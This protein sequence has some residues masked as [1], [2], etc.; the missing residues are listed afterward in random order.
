MLGGIW[1][2]MLSALPAYKEAKQKELAQQAEQAYREALIQQMRDQ[3]AMRLKEFTQRQQEYTDAA[4]QREANLGLTKEQAA[5]AAFNNTFGGKVY[6]AIVPAVAP[7]ITHV[8]GG[9]FDRWAGATPDATLRAQIDREQITSHER[10]TDKQIAAQ[11]AIAAAKAPKSHEQTYHEKLIRD[12]QAQ[13]QDRGI[14]GSLADAFGFSSLVPQQKMSLLDAELELAQR[15]QGIKPNKPLG[16][17]DQAFKILQDALGPVAA[18]NKAFPGNKG[19]GAGKV[20]G[21]DLAKKIYE[22][23]SDASKLESWKKFFDGM[24][25]PVKTSWGGTVDKS[26]LISKISKFI[27]DQASK[28]FTGDIGSYISAISQ[29]VSAREHALNPSLGLSPTDPRLHNAFRR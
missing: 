2:G 6:N 3:E 22:E 13:G 28:G 23:T 26:D 16:W 27:T 14:S 10:I 15:K 24:G 5:A 19:A 21:T 18:A 12:I 1:G 8:G 4:P 7:L 11:K 25:D 9:L 29:D 20:P 17:K